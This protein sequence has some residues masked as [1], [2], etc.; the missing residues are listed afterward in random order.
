MIKLTFY[1]GAGEIGGNKFL[2][3]A[4]DTRIF[5][6]FGMSYPQEEKFF[7]FPLLRPSCLDDLLKTGILPRLCGLYKNGGLSVTYTEDGTPSLYGEEEACGVDGI[8]LSHAHMDH[9]G[10][11]GMLRSDIPVYLS[12]ISRRLIELRNDIREEWQT[13]VDMEALVAVEK[14]K[15]FAVKSI[16]VRRFDVDH[17]V[18]GASAFLIRT[19]DKVIAYTGDLRLH[20]STPQD[21]REFLKACQQAGV[22]ILL[23]EG[24]R[25]GSPSQEEGEQE[26]ESHTLDSEEEVE[27]KCRDILSREGDLVIYDASPADMNRMRLVCRV[28][29]EFGRTPVFDSR[30]AYLLLYLN[31]TQALCPGLPKAGDFK[32]A[33]SRL[34]LRANRYEKYGLPEDLYAETLTDYRGGHEARLLGKVG[35]GEAPEDL[36]KLPDGCFIWGPLRDEV[37]REPGRYLLYTS[38]GLHT[39]LHFLPADGRKLRGTYIYGKAEPFK[40]EMEFSFK[41]LRHWLELCG[42][43]LD[44]AHTSGHMHQS[45]LERFI[46][47]IS[48]KTV[49]PIHTE[50]PEVFKQWAADVRIPGLGETVALG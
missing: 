31:W 24:T 8:L 39:L 25:V 44:Y 47:E 29:R 32:I 3:E 48:P 35:K 50:H 12:P 14:S 45:D 10:Y 30:K 49:I 11:L 1:G 33:L 6:D 19:G 42:L 2:L 20:G 4:A 43:K 16:R 9:Y 28:A 38:S 27:R 17:S 5:L 18:L 15:E 13:K 37:L 23:C 22:D 46:A 36:I 26:T 34:K 21:T 7:E 41:R 40:E